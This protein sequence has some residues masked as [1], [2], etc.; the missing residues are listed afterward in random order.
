MLV[1]LRSDTVTR[2]SAEMRRR[3][4][5]AEVGDDIYGEDPSV[6]ALEERVASLLGKERALFVPSGTMSNQLA[7]MVQTKRGDEIVIGEGSHCAWFESGA[8]GALS[9]VQIAVAGQGGLFDVAELEAA[10]K[11]KA[12]YMPRTAL[13]VL[14]NSHNRSGGRVFPQD[15]AERVAARARELSLAVHLDGARLW[16]AAAATGLS[17][18][19]LA[20]PADTVSVCFSKGLGAPVGS[21]LVGPDALLTEAHRFRRMLGG[22]MRQSGILAAAAL[23]ALDANMSRLVEDHDK[24]KAFARVLSQ[25]RG[26]RVDV[27]A[28]E[29]NIVNVVLERANED[30]VLA[31][32]KERGVLLGTIALRT[33]RAV[34]HLDASAA[35]VERGAGLLAAVIEEQTHA[36]EEHHT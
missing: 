18:E 24:A 13:V 11:P 12:F 3:M 15:A 6:R 33:L 22:A 16:N 26:A 8:A 2:P 32:A 7:L 1:D 5:A 4:A 35:D 25:A 23:Y 9:G 31:A 21:A 28:V 29:T 19:R 34:M 14:E 10:L 30:A 36:A 20:R 17:L 27:S